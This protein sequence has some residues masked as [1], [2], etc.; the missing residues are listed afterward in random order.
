MTKPVKLQ[1]KVQPAGTGFVGKPAGAA[2][3]ALPYF[4][5]AGQACATLSVMHVIHLISFSSALDAARRGLSK[6]LCSIPVPHS[7]LAVHGLQGMSALPM[8]NTLTVYLFSFLK[9]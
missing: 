4:D 5:Q 9:Q 2:A 8:K 6:T 3:A 7:P 1:P